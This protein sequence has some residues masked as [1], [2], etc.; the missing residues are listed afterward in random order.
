MGS[1]RGKLNVRLGSPRKRGMSPFCP[2]LK[3]THDRSSREIEGNA[4]AAEPLSKDTDTLFVPLK[5]NFWS[6]LREFTHRSVCKLT[7]TFTNQNSKA[8]AIDTG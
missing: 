5:H 1:P 7:R 2:Q 4:F 3:K 6:W 8:S